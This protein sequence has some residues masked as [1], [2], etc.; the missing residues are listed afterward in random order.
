MESYRQPTEGVVISG[1]GYGGY[2]KDSRWPG[3]FKFPVE[4][5][6]EFHTYAVDWSE[7]GYIFYFDGKEIGRRMADEVPVSH[8]EQFILVSTEVHGYHRAFCNEVPESDPSGN[9][10][11]WAGKPISSLK[12]A[13]FPDE[14]VVDYVRVFDRVK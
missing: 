1:I 5:T 7:E 6:E 12:K 13:T 4:N 11:V 14:F 9:A 10:N 2:G 8:V 3:H